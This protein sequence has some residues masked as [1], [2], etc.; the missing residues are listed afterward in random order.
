VPTTASAA[1]VRG[2]TLC[3]LNDA[4]RA[5]GLPSLRHNP[6]LA[7]AATRHAGDMAARAYF[8]HI[9]PDGRSFLDRVKQVG[10]LTGR[11]R[12]WTVGENLAW[13]AGQRAAPGEI[14]SAWMRSSPHRANI[15]SHR[16]RE[17]GF[18]MA[19]AAPPAGGALPRT[20]YATEFGARR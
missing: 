15:L 14:F 1:Q 4:R 17:V 13:G 12:R 10:Y 7:A 16:F 5:R 9:S 2:S 8:S 6:V 18:G 20:V 11:E 19:V 3:L